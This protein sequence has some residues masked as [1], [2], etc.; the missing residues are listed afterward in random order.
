MFW[1]VFMMMMVLFAGCASVQPVLTQTDTVRVTEIQRDTV[2]EVQPDEA[3]IDA[4]LSCDSLNRVVLNQ[5][6]Q[7]EGRI[8]EL[9]YALNTITGDTVYQVL[10]VSAETPARFDSISWIE[11]YTAENKMVT[12]TFVQKVKEPPWWMKLVLVIETI[13]ILALTVIIIKKPR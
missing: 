2:I 8:I 4:Y 12:E 5:V 6:I 10:R 11:R 9:Q 7:Q 1:L 13:A 3:L